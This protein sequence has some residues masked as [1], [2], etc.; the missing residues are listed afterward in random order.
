M[1]AGLA[2]AFVSES[3]TL[4]EVVRDINKFSNNV[5]AQQ[6]FLT[7]S[8][9]AGAGPLGSSQAAVNDARG[10]GSFE[11]SRLWVQRWWRDRV[12]TQPSEGLDAPVL[13]NGSGL[14]RD[15]RISAL[16]LAR[17][18][19]WA[20][21]QPTMSE[22][23]SSLPVTGLDGT[24]KRSK[25]QAV[26]HLKTGSL[27]D[28]AGIARYKVTH[29]NE[30]MDE[31]MSQQHQSNVNPAQEP[32]AAPYKDC[33][34]EVAGIKLHYQ[35][36]GTT[37]KPYMICVHGGAA[38]GHWFDF[39]AGDFSRNYHVLAIDQDRKSTRLNSS[40]SQQSRMPSSA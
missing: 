39:V 19:Q 23:M 22:L 29:L 9:Q 18:L 35:D 36:F 12:V 30:R 40:H 24:L 32:Q 37:G 20:W 28:V 31:R 7:L 3:P 1:P 5:M 6:V 4:A 16:A 10:V 34:L 21:Q 11:A 27:R 26:A 14:S 15:E 38:S 8:L 2:P 13:E 25:A 33:Y 17:L